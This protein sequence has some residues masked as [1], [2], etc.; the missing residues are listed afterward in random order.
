MHE[1]FECSLIYL[2]VGSQ[3]ITWL[4]A[5]S[6]SKKW[7]T[8]YMTI[9][10]LVLGLAINLGVY[11]T[12]NNHNGNENLY[13]TLGVDR[14]SNIAEIRAGFK[15]KSFEYHP[16][17]NRAIDAE[18]SFLRIK[19]AYDVLMDDKQ[20][21]I[22]NR[23]GEGVLPNDPRAEEL[24][25]I[26]QLVTK[27]LLWII[28]TYICTINAAANVSRTWLSIL[29]IALLIAEVSMC[30]SSSWKVPTNAWNVKSSLTEH[31]LIGFCHSLFPAA[32]LILRCIA[33]FIYV[34]IDAL[35]AEIL[36]A[37]GTQQI[38]VNNAIAVVQRVIVNGT[39]SETDKNLVMSLRVK[40]HELNGALENAV[41]RL[42]VPPNDPLSKYYWLLF[43]LI[44]GYRYAP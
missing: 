29:G 26:V 19:H 2:A 23:F 28:A 10:F 21:D 38:E 43:V 27:Y 25:Y 37:I 13:K 31:E 7:T 39:A 15:T 11:M 12:L 24:K 30:L 35:S 4:R 33:E 6:S 8:L 14:F 44:Y 32:I 18:K 34:D 17:K 16:D 9:T 1:P 3:L 36:V 22:Y 41:A 42:N 5:D 20:R 40:I